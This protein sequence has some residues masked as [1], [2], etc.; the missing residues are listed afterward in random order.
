MVEDRRGHRR[1]GGDY[2]GAEGPYFKVPS[3]TAFFNDE[4]TAEEVAAQLREAGFSDVQ[5]DYVQRFPADRGNVTD[6]P[7][8]GSLTGQTGELDAALA[9]ADPAISGMAGTG[10][11]E[12]GSPYMVIAVLEDDRRRQEA[13]NIIEEHRRKQD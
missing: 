7:F 3:V 12:T 4:K 8:P 1:C 6:Q 9:S 10:G 5:V 11:L 2:M 13:L